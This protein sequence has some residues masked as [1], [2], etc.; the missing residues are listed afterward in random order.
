VNS[1]QVLAAL[2]V[3]L[4]LVILIYPAVSSGNISVTIGGLK[5][6]KADHVYVTVDGILLHARGQS[7]T[8]GWKLVSNQSQTFDLISLVNLTRPL[9]TSQIS[10]ARYDS[11]RLSLSNVTWVFNK[12]TTSLLIGSPNLDANLEFTL[13]AGRG[14]TIT[15]LLGGHEEVIGASK[16]FQATMTATATEVS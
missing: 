8:T 11:V 9:A 7:N 2:S 5:I 1:K 12:T 13:V 6:D 14:L 15:I 16:F 3:V 10:V 4:L